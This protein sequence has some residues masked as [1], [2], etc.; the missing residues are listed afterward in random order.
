M[1]EKRILEALKKDDKLVLKAI[2]LEHKPAFLNFARRFNINDEDS[3]DIY[4]DAI[5]ALRENGLKGHLDTLK[6]ELKS[7]LF[8]IGKYMI[9]DRLK[10]KK[11]LFAKETIE[12]PVDFDSLKTTRIDYNFSERQRQ[13]QHALKLLGAQCQKVLNLFYFRGFS[14]DEIVIELS[15]NNKDV[16]KSQKSRCIKT[17]KTIINKTK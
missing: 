10:E 15:Y 12:E 9:Y 1:V 11:K 3:L 6:S 4:Q 16:V 5:M 7:Y 14:L 13:L 8:S 17:L 2:Y